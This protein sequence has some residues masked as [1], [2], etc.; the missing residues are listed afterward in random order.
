M[1][2]YVSVM[3]DLRNLLLQTALL[4]GSLLLYQ[5]ALPAYFTIFLYLLLRKVSHGGKFLHCVTFAKLWIYTMGITA[6]LYAPVA[7]N[8][9]YVHRNRKAFEGSNL[10]GYMEFV[11]K[12]IGGYFT[13]IYVNWNHTIV[14]QISFLF[15]VGFLI[16][17][18]ME[19]WKYKSSGIDFARRCLVI[20]PLFFLFL[21]SPA[22][23]T[24]LFNHAGNYA[25]GEFP[26][27]VIYSAPIVIAL[28]LEGAQP[29]F[30]KIYLLR[31]FS[32]VFAGIFLLWNISFTNLTGNLL[33][34]Q[35]NIQND[36][37]KDIAEDLYNIK[38]HCDYRIAVKY[39]YPTFWP[40]F[41]GAFEE[42][43]VLKIIL[44]YQ[45]HRPIFCNVL[46][47][48]NGRWYPRIFGQESISDKAI[49]LADR[50]WYALY[51]DGDTLIIELKPSL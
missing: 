33:E 28:A 13:E 4:F 18:L 50:M 5:G 45:W 7:Y 6:V 44:G 30:S 2:A 27:R 20:S 19:T 42:Y 39:P 8:L 14:G 51:A 26:P 31:T 37:A 46:L 43:P 24:I 40:A 36:I 11:W 25:A 15:I 10:W 1:A 48:Y 21:L 47:R 9:N 12:R 41:V 29:L 17:L 16:H 35:F 22:G 23:L 32:K 49:R 3:D 38:N 34:R